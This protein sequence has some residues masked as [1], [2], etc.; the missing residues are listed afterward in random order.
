MD[1][2][3]TSGFLKVELSI[4]CSVLIKRS[5]YYCYFSYSYMSFKRIDHFFMI[6]NL[7]CNLSKISAYSRN[8]RINVR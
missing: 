7:K 2:V 6:K 4:T 1:L 8:G 3:Y 5:L